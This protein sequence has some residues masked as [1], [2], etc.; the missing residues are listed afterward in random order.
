[1]ATNA[2]AVENSG[3]FATAIAMPQQAAVKHQQ[4]SPAGGTSVAVHPSSCFVEREDNENAGKGLGVATFVLLIIGFIFS[5]ILPIVALIANITA[6][7]LAS[8]LQCGCCCANEYNLKPNAKKYLTSTFVSICFAFIVQIV[9]I[10]GA[11]WSG[12]LLTVWTAEGAGNGLL[13]AW[14]FGLLLHAMAIIFSA[15]FTW[16]SK[17]C[18]C[19]ARH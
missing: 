8:I 10:Y 13:F 4:S 17:C 9:G 12:R 18:S 7:V 11:L 3:I 14:I 1:M 15:H 16:G 5:F 19:S 2:A 6:L